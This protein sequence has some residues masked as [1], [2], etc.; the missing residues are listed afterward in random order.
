MF[1]RSFEPEIKGQLKG[2]MDFAG[3][4]A[5]GVNLKSGYFYNA[6]FKV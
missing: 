2:I 1:D 5:S 6:F 3:I 4:T